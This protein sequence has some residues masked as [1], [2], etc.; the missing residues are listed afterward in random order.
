MDIQLSQQEATLLRLVSG[1]FG[2]ESVAVNCR[3]SL[4]CG[5]T[6]PGELYGEFPHLERWA[7]TNRC[8]LTVVDPDDSPALVIE[9]F[10]GHGDTIDIDEMEKQRYLAALLSA[11][12]ILY[13]TVSDDDLRLATDPDSGK[14]LSDI[15]HE[16]IEILRQ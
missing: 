1:I 14:C 9:L 12:K 3:V 11:K 10:S 2:V 15:L 7:R 6:Y 8:L 4:V 13:I 16:K 5:G